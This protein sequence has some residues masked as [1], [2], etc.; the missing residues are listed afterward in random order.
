MLGKEEPVE[1]RRIG[2]RVSTLEAKV[3]TMG[4]GQDKLFEKLDSLK[5]WLVAIF[6]TGAGATIMVA[7]DL[8]TRTPVK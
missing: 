3:E 5:L 4:A 1:E 6:A 8:A 7:V 2:E